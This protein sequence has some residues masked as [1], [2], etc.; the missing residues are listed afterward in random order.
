MLRNKK[1]I[2][3]VDILLII[4]L[5][6]YLVFFIPRN[7]SIEDFENLRYGE[8]SLI[9][10]AKLGKPNE[11][12]IGSGTMLH[13]FQYSLPDGTIVSLS[14]GPYLLRL[15]MCRYVKDG[16]EVDIVLPKTR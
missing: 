2:L 8:F 15:T 3:F 9:V 1:F 13:Y 12:H 16:M 14:F 11:I 6:V 5:S 4:I 10:L 7:H